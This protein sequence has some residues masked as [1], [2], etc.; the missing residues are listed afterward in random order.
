M[1]EYMLNHPVLTFII[2]I[3]IIITIDNIIGNLITLKIS[4]LEKKG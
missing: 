1:T 4:K 2:I 3:M